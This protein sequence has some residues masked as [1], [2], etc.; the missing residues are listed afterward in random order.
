MDSAGQVDEILGLI[1]ARARVHKAGPGEV[2]ELSR[3]DIVPFGS[4]GGKQTLRRR[5]NRQF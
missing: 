5:K 2:D 4:V 3:V 1:S